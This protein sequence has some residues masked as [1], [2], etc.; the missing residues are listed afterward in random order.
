LL[1]RSLNVCGAKIAFSRN[2]PTTNVVISHMA[3]MRRKYN[4]N[5][6]TG[7]E[8][9]NAATIEPRHQ[10]VQVGIMLGRPKSKS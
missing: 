2:L 1:F 10:V 8:H 7:L 6:K 9:R 5:T 4:A 3:T